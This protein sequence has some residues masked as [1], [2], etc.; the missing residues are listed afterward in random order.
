MESVPRRRNLP[1]CDRPQA[2]QPIHRLVYGLQSMVTSLCSRPKLAFP[3]FSSD[4]R[5]PPDLYHSTVSLY[6]TLSQTHSLSVAAA[7]PQCSVCSRGIAEWVAVEEFAAS[8][9]GRRLFECQPQE[10]ETEVGMAL[11][12]ENRLLSASLR[13]MGVAGSQGGKRQLS[14]FGLR[15]GSCSHCMKEAASVCQPQRRESQER[16]GGGLVAA[17]LDADASTYRPRQ[18]QGQAPSLCS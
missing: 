16:E 5:I 18:P 8:S 6:G 7:P 10:R 1:S 4:F 14:V 3:H 2:L 17:R 9:V 12:W 13:H 11:Q 15:K